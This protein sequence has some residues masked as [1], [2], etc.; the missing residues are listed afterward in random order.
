MSLWHTGAVSELAWVS[1][2]DLDR[3]ILVVAL[4][5]LFDA[6]GSATDAV[7]HLSGLRSTTKVAEIDPETFFDFTQQRPTVALDADGVRSLTWP[8]NDT[9]AAPGEG[10]RD[11]LLL[12]GVEPHLRWRSFSEAICEIAKGANAELVVTLGAM[13]GMAPH[14]RPL[15]VIGSTTNADLAS[16]MGLSRPSYEGPTGLVGAL[17]DSLDKADLPVISL[18][19]SVPH[20][21]PSPPNPEATRSL[22]ARFELVTGIITDHADFDDDAAEW[23]ARVDAAVLDDSEMTRYVEDLERQVDSSADE[24]LPSGEDLAAELQAFLRDLHDD[25][26]S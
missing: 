5:G 14:T 11:L 4:R 10:H 12:S 24:L 1:E 17:H 13:V 23:R 16:R 25:D 19:V 18:R 8:A 26:E 22:L 2:P 7:E 21:V 6:A 3:P 15:G 9:F 20:Y